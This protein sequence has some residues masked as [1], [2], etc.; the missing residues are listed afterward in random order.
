MGLGL[1]VETA[2][3]VGLVRLSKSRSTPWVRIVVLVDAASGKDSNVN[4]LEEAAVGQVQ[5]ADNIGTHRLLLVVLAPVDIGTSR[6]AGS[7][8]DVGG[9]DA[10]ELGDD[11]LAVLHADRRGVDFLALLLED[12][13]Q[14]TGDPAL[15][16]PDEE[17]VRGGGAVGAVG[18][19]GSHGG[20]YYIAE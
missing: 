12:R 6:A 8:E 4:A 7:I 17:A 18:T 14:V 10:L 3:E 11:S 16:T 9:L 2:T 20:L 19:V 5:C 1:R 13:L 15:A